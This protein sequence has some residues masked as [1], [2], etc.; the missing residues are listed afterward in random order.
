MSIACAAITRPKLIIADEPVSALDVTIQAQILELLKK[1]KESG[2]LSYLF[3]SHDLNVIWQICNKV[4][5][6]QHGQIVEYGD[7]KKVFRHPE[8]PY[9]QSLLMDAM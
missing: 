1:L 3:I 6:M 9:T 4:M 7:T 5:V 8:H 2:S